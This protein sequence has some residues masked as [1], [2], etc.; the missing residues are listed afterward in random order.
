M[1]GD[2][3]RKENINES[4]SHGSRDAL[5]GFIINEKEEP[6]T[7]KNGEAISEMQIAS[8]NSLA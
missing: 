5:N 2:T 4:V 1:I 3:K 7:L 8:G 6:S